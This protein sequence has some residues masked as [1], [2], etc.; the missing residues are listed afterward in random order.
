[1]RRWCLD[2]GKGRERGRKSRGV[3]AF[4]NQLGGAELGLSLRIEGY[5]WILDGLIR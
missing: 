2:R 4:Q 1:V 3:G 5:M